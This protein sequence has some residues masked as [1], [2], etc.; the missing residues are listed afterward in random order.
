MIT[1][2]PE[3]E[4]LDHKGNRVSGSDGIRLAIGNVAGS[5]YSIGSIGSYF[6][7]NKRRPPKVILNEHGVSA[8]FHVTSRT[9]PFNTYCGLTACEDSIPVI[10][11][12]RYLLGRPAY[13]FYDMLLLSP[14]CDTCLN[15]PHFDLDKL[16]LASDYGM[17]NL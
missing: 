7:I 14:G 3:W 17:E 13:S 6:N 15:H 2:E 4:I 16:S 9:Q 8:R 5:D 12:L 10:Y 11:Y 1:E